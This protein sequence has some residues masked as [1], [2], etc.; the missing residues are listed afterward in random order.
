MSRRR[1][2]GNGGKRKRCRIRR[3]EY[4]IR[5]AIRR[6]LSEKDFGGPKALSW[7]TRARALILQHYS[8]ADYE[9]TVDRIVDQLSRT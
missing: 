3:P 4:R 1:M 8:K 6:W 5:R 2:T 9:A 7:A